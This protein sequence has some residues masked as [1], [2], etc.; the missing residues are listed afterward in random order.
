MT[1]ALYLL[2]KGISNPF[3]QIMGILWD[4]L[5]LYE[6]SAYGQDLRDDLREAIALIRYWLNHQSNKLKN[7][8]D[9]QKASNTVTSKYILVLGSKLIIIE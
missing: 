3:E 5:I 8:Q 2:T 9:V 1:I 4:F 6:L 7:D